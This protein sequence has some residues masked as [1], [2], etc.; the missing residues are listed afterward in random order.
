[1]VGNE[2]TEWNN[3]LVSEIDER[4]LPQWAKKLVAVGFPKTN[5]LMGYLKWDIERSA[6]VAYGVFWFPSKRTEST[7]TGDDYMVVYA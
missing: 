1:M 6:A 7:P 2:T 4:T 3:R 5:V